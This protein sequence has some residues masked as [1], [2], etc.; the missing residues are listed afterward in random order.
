MT[1]IPKIPLIPNILIA[2]PHIPTL[3][4]RVRTLIPRVPINLLIPFPDS[5]FRLLEIVK[6]NI[7]HTD[8]HQFLCDLFW[9]WLYTYMS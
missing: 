4:S 9:N 5:P 7:T 1:L 6:N 3:I 8:D 2:I